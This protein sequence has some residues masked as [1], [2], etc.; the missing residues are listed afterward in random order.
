MKNA[1][2][3]TLTAAL[4]AGLVA[5][6]ALTVS[7]ETLKFVSWQVDDGGMGDWWQAAIAKFEEEHPDVS[8]EF[9][10]VERASYADTMTT[11]FAE[12]LNR[13]RSC[14]SPRSNI[15]ASPRMAGLKT[16]IPGPEKDGPSIWSG[17]A[18]Q[19]KCRWNDETACIMLL[20]FGFIMA[21]NPSR[22]WPRPASTV[23]TNLG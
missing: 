9:T 8:I 20:Y 23:P 16:S 4:T 19:E 21:Y 5:T 15:R 12:R 17:W 22:S 6:S 14:I 1:L 10:K 11:L 3:T 18:G 13:R 2:K 7:A